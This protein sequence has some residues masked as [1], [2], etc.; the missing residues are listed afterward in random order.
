MKKRRK[1]R[2]DAAIA[3]LI[4]QPSDTDPQGSWTGNP[5]HELQPPVLEAYF[6]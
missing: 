1:E 6:L 2:I 3:P 4:P 5:V